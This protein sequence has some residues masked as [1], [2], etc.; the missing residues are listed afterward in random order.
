MSNIIAC[1]LG[2]YAGFADRAWTH[3]PEVGLRHLEIDVPS[4]AEVEPLQR[5]LS[6]SGV[7]ISSMQ[8]DLKIQQDDIVDQL[9]PQL[10]TMGAFGTGFMFLSVNSGEQDPETT[11]PRLRAAGDL[12][13]EHDVTLVLETHPN[14]ITNGDV[15]R[16]T[17]QQVNHPHVRVNYDTANVHYNN[18]NVDSIEELEKVIDYVGAVHLKDSRGGFESFDF[19]SLGH[20]IV[21]FPKVFELLGGSGF[22]GPCTMELQGSEDVDRDN[23]EQVLKHIAESVA[24]LRQ[25]GA[26]D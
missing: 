5:R 20:G 16:R 17:M 6:E 11:W 26:M 21:D 15:A 2:C 25:I 4:A 12:A 18:K 19:P 24:Y 23:E 14:L 1:R 10:E 22:S 8:G 13:A 3:M 9:G 7:S